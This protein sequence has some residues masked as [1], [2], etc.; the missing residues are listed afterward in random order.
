MVMQKFWLIQQNSAVERSFNTLVVSAK[1]E[2]LQQGQ[3]C[4]FPSSL[5]H[6]P[7]FINE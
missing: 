3:C 6:F 2:E 5:G 1:A 7:A 4:T